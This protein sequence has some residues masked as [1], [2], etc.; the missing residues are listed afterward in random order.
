MI[1]RLK[2]RSRVILLGAVP[3]LVCLFIL[4]AS[5]WVA[6]TKDSFFHRLYDEHLAVLSDVMAAQRLYSSI[7]NGWPTRALMP[8][9]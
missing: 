8:L 3:T 6:D 9:K 4:V 2:I 1:S 5:I 7:N